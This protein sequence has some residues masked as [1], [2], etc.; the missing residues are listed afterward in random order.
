LLILSRCPEVLAFTNVTLGFDVGG[1]N[2]AP[3]KCF[4][5]AGATHDTRR[6]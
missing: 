5:M 4:L 1:L 3:A 6:W 2:F